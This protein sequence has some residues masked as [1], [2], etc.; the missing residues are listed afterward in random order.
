MKARTHIPFGGH[1]SQHG[2]VDTAGIVVLPLCY[3][4]SPSYGSGSGEGPYHI[5]TAS[6]QLESIDEETLVDWVDLGIHTLEPLLPGQ[7]PADAIR[8]MQDAAESVLSR[9]RFLLSLGGDHAISLGPIR[10]AASHFPDLGI[11]QIDAHLDLRDK[12]NGSRYNHACVMRRVVEDL[13]LKVKPVGTRS[14]S[15]EEADLVV[16]QVVS[17]VFAHQIAERTDDGWIDE[18]VSGLPDTVYVTIDL[19]GLDPAA[20]PGTGTPEPG[21]LTYRQVTRLLRRTGERRQVVAADINELA[22]IPGTQVSET[23]AAKIATKI[24]VYCSGLPV[25][26]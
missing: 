18:I 15:P 5:L 8:Q 1:E 22:K 9:G 23:T 24:M 21:G 4:Q 26:G 14:F 3:E 11:L 2:D 12:W 16:K 20:L 25:D 6:E 10:A 17:P 7:N 13:G 19:D